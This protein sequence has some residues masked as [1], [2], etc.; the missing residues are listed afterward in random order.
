MVRALAGFLP[1]G[2]VPLLPHSALPPEITVDRLNR[3]KDILRQIDD[4]YRQKESGGE[5]ARYSDLKQQALGVL[6]ASKLADAFNLGKESPKLV[7]RY[8]NEPLYQLFH[9]HVLELVR[10]FYHLRTVM[11]TR[12]LSIDISSLSSV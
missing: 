2:G 11:L 12:S 7:E 10:F 6:S 1:G 3:R 4:A 8:G 5:M 9:R